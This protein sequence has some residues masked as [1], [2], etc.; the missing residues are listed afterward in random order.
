MVSSRI[1]RLSAR[2]IAGIIF[3]IAVV[4]RIA[5]IYAVIGF[6]TG[7][8]DVLRLNGDERDYL[9]RA[10]NVMMGHGFTAGGEH[11]RM[12]RT[13]AYPLLLLP[14]TAVGGRELAAIR[15]LQ[16]LL[17]SL[18]CVLLFAVA[19]RVFDPTVAALAALYF[20]L[21]PPHAHMAG[22]ILSENLLLPVVLLATL[23]F[24]RAAETPTVK[25]AMLGGMLAGLA[26]LVKPEAGAIA[27]VMVAVMWLI[28][29]ERK[30]LR[31]AA[32]LL[33][34][35]LTLAP[36]L[37]RNYALSGRFVIS[38]VGGEAF[39]GGNNE[40]VLDVPKHRG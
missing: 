25:Q 10:E 6:H 20:A 18:A 21:Y 26:A 35:A 40:Y 29:G 23:Q 12:W 16:A 19:R 22:Q 4:V 5:F 38:S 27:G 28:A 31:G 39:W 36:W 33:A 9:R 13:P 3:A 24:L 7:E 2:S 32:L 17:G 11:D 34:A 1:A 30:V 37:A 8:S 15:F 14:I